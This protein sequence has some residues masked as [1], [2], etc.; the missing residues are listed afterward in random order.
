MKPV[1]YSLLLGRH[2]FFTT[3][4]TEEHR[5]NTLLL[6]LLTGDRDLATDNC[7]Q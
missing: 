7:F 2:F 6:R 5:R 4:D 3:E 1:L